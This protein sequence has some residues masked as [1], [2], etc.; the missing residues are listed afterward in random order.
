MRK[1]QLPKNHFK[2]MNI[3]QIQEILINEIENLK[4]H[5]NKDMIVDSIVSLIP[6]CFAGN[7]L[8]ILSGSLVEI[9][10]SSVDES[11]TFL[12]KKKKVVKS[13][14]NVGSGYFGATTGAAYGSVFGPIGAVIGGFAGAAAGSGISNRYVENILNKDIFKFIF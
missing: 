12:E 9:A 14:L 13:S 3:Q 5:S 1:R 8:A 7:P 6:L 11:L 4:S 2:G 10:R